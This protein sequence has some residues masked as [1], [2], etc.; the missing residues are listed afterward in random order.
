MCS[1]SLALIRTCYRSTPYPSVSI[2]I[3]WRGHGHATLFLW[4][5]TLW[6]SETDSGGERKSFAGRKFGPVSIL[7]FFFYRAGKGRGEAYRTYTA[8]MPET[9]TFL[10]LSTFV[11]KGN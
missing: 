1:D 10:L 3:V 5:S 6:V 11:L 9:A 7:V 2:I 8:E 4:S